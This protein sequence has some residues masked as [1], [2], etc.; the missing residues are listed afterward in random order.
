MNYTLDYNPVPGAPRSTSFHLLFDLCLRG[1][2]TI[3][4]FHPSG[5][6][7]TV[8]RRNLREKYAGW[9]CNTQRDQSLCA[10]QKNF[11]KQHIKQQL[12]PRTQAYFNN[13]AEKDL[14]WLHA[15]KTYLRYPRNNGSG[16]KSENSQTVTDGKHLIQLQQVGARTLH[17]VARLPSFLWRWLSWN[18]LC[19]LPDMMLETPEQ[20]IPDST[21]K[22]RCKQFL[23][24]HVL[25]CVFMCR[26]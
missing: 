18:N 7:A 26:W 19:T 9:V 23:P 3:Q 10:F 14:P 13:G 20:G 24:L 25:T 21:S 16:W 22:G 11:F 5:Q 12:T 17:R 4:G 6:W 15:N 2:I 8:G 1:I